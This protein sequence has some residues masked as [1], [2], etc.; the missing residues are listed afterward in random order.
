MKVEKIEFKPLF[1]EVCGLPFI[2]TGHHQWLVKQAL[3]RNIA[4][5]MNLDGQRYGTSQSILKQRNDLV[6]QGLKTDATHFVF[7]DWDLI[8]P[9]DAI[10]RLAQHEVDFVGGVQYHK[11]KWDEPMCYV[12]GEWYQGKGPEEVDVIGAGFT[13]ISRKVFEALEYPYFTQSTDK[14]DGDW[15][16]CQ[17]VKEKGFKIW[18]DFTLVAE[19]LG[20]FSNRDK[21]LIENKEVINKL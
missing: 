13:L 12:D 9:D 18:C 6:Q 20:V 3:A 21:K 8:P 15:E 11:D 14:N 19:H 10:Q 16:F 1:L 4:G 17:K 2:Y 7:V 5:Y